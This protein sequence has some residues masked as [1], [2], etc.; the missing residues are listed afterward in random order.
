MASERNIEVAKRLGYHIYHYDKDVEGR[1][2]YQLWQP[3]GEP[4]GLYHDNE[5][6][7]ELEAW[8][9]APCWDSDLNLAFELLKDVPKFTMEK[10]ND[11][12]LVKVA[13]VAEIVQVVTLDDLPGAIVDWWLTHVD[14][15][16]LKRSREIAKLKEKIADLRD[17]LSEM[18]NSQTDEKR[19][20]DN[21]DNT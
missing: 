2:Y 7:T 5:Y 12:W 8:Q 10:L 21:G 15:K 16:A 6:K 17:E 4:V 14:V 11:A 18:E 1:C 13:T 9:V 19:A 3:D 20:M